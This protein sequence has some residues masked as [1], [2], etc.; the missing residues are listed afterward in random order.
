MLFSIEDIELLR[1][2]RWCRYVEP[3]DLAGMFNENTIANLIYLNYIRKHGPTG[4]L[5]LS[6]KGNAFLSEHFQDIPE[7]RRVITRYV[8]RRTRVSK[9][10]LTAY[11]AGFSLST[12]VLNSLE[13]NSTFFLPAIER[14]SGANPWSNS[15]IAALIRLGNTLAAAH[16]VCMDI[17]DILLADELTAFNNNTAKIKKVNRA[18]IFAGEN[19]RSILKELDKTAKD[20][21]GI[22][23]CYGDAYRNVRMPVYLLSCDDTGATQL[24]IMAQPDYR[25]RL[26]MAALKSQYTPPPDDHPEWDAVFQGVPFVLAADME[27]R[28]VDSAIQSAKAAGIGQIAMAALKGQVQT[29]LNRRY[30]DTGKARVFTLTDEALRSLGDLTLYSPSNR[31]YET[32]KGDVIDAPLIQADR[33]SG[34]PRRK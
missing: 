30:R 31:Q 29:V 34:G 33:K 24:R 11:R 6:V 23:I 3:T 17:G 20:T 22:L 13:N 9:L 26:T 10:A 14:K 19:Y 5:T 12:T 2:L 18:L 7:F 1:F 16:Y 25:R 27:L 4:V 8:P 21:E 15:R 32:A 28:R